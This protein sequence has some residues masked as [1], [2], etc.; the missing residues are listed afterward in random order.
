RGQQSE[1]DCS[2]QTAFKRLVEWRIIRP[3][4]T[5]QEFRWRCFAVHW[6]RSSAPLVWIRNRRISSQ[7]AWSTRT[8]EETTHT[9]LCMSRTTSGS[10][11]MAAS[12]H[13]ESPRLVASSGSVVRVDA[14]NVMG[15]I[16]MTFAMKQAIHCA[17]DVGVAFAAVGGSNHCG[18]LNYFS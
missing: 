17:A 11:C 15:Q 2:A 4:M 6:R 9:A 7:M 3:V 5:D 18:A 16:G 12:I 14:D 13:A 1:L 10:W 8:E